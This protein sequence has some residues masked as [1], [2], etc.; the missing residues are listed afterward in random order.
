MK[1]VVLDGVPLNPGDLD[2][3]PLHDLGEVRIHERTAPGQVAERIQ[4][5]VAVFSN[6]VKIT[7]DHMAAAPDLKFIGVMATGYDNI[8]VPAARQRGVAVANVPSYS[9]AF[10]AQTAIALL[11]ELA[12][13]VGHHAAEVRGGRWSENRD[14]SFW[15]YPLVE[16]KGK[17]MLIVGLGTIGAKVAK[18]AEAL[19]MRVVAA[20]LPGR[21]LTSESRHVPLDEAL[22]KADVV[23][24]HC[25]LNDTTRHLV[26]EARLQLF[27]PGAMLIN[28]ARGGLVDEAALAA[29]L[30]SGHLAGFAG[31]VLSAEPPPATNPLLDAPN[32]LLTPHIGWASREARQRLLDTCA[33]NL[34]S[35]VQGAPQNLVSLLPPVKVEAK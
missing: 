32:C 20:S 8:D 24:L 14:F 25:P 5:A 22:P 10:T 3:Q 19:G 35:F 4:D 34:R 23:S 9:S 21:P 11:L 6:K 30:R 27:K 12:H 31:D 18:V 17:T 13:H 28:T 29:A 16:L 2:W 7:A 15:D 26:N 33:I 1:I